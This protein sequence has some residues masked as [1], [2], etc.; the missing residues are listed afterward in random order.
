MIIEL[1]E[2]LE[3]N[4][5]LPVHWV[6][7]TE[8]ERRPCASLRQTLVDTRHGLAKASGWAVT[9]V[10]LQ[11]YADDYERLDAI[12]AELIAIY[13]GWLDPIVDG[14]SKVKIYVDDQDDDAFPSPDGSDDWVYARSINLRIHHKIEG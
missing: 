9:G 10:E 8:M 6:A 2:H 5:G 11:I 1:R 14:G 13:D 7:I 12:A 3:T 4:L